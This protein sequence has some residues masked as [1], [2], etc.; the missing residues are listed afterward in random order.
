MTYHKSTS[1]NCKIE[2]GLGED[3]SAFLASPPE[4]TS[5]EIIK[6]FDAMGIKKYL[7]P[8]LF[9]ET[10]E[11]A[12]VAIS[13]T[14]PS[15]RILYV[16]TAFEQLTGY[17]REEVVGQN[18]S[19]LSSRSTPE[20]VYQELWQTI[21]NSRLWKGNL[22]NHRKSGEEYLAELMISP[23]LDPEGRIAYFLGMHRDITEL[24]QLEQQLKFQ[25][26]LTEVALDAAPMVVAVLDSDGRV[27]LDNHAYKALLGDFRGAEP[28]TLFLQALEQQIGF[29]L[30][31]DCQAGK[32]FTNVD[33]RLDPPGRGSPRW[34]SCSGVR[35]AELDEAA[36]Y[37]FE[38]TPRIHCRLLLI[39]NEV[40]YSR[41][42]INEARLNMIRAS[43]A[44][45]Q[46]VQAM[47]EALHGSIFKLQAPLNVIRAALSMTDG[48]EA[49]PGLQTVLRQALETGEEAMESLHDALPSPT[50]ERTSLVNVNEIL[51]EVIGLS[52]DRL[53]ANGVVVDWR[54]APVLPPVS[55]C[56][57]A[58]R[59]LF[60]YL[61]DNAMQAVDES[62][63]DY[64]EIRL[65]TSVDD[66]ELL[67]EV[68]D[69]GPGLAQSL[70][71]KAF[72]PFF[73]GWSNPVGHAGM[74]LTL[75]QEVVNGHGGG[76]EIDPD[77]L[78]GCRVRV[79]L[80]KEGAGRYRSE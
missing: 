79:R 6:A 23:V 31:T 75:A 73:C 5:L 36:Q 27:L 44:E 18:E 41:Q 66:D 46:M 64:R 21:K 42:R 58:L 8:K 68:M 14:D 70:R 17:S 43:M 39:A 77:F 37:Y 67:I 53:L 56:A 29:N 80:P 40:T 57:N 19:V 38:Q 13:I 15:A 4:G 28:A 26:N 1:A 59:G 32:G 50:V 72:E 63:K 7:P 76:I 71:L 25:K 45:Q 47:R 2:C 52:T 49:H 54:P 61:L 12:P 20:S 51:H 9:L 24:H 16:N 55:A 30:D 3:I 22:V 35:V 33:V 78:G 62:G 34:F 10:V 65:S 74:G 11:Q 60:K 69:N 48:M